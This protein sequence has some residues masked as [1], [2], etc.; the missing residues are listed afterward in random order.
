MTLKIRK[1][2]EKDFPSFLTLLYE[3]ALFDGSPKAA[4]KNS[5]EQMKKEKKYINFF[6]AEEG[7]KVVG[8]AVYSFVYYTWA[9]KSIFLED[10]YITS[11]C[12]GKGIGT[13]LLTKVFE[14]AK[15]EN[16]N[17]LRWEVEE[18][19]IVAQEFYRKLGAKTGDTWFDCD[20]GKEGIKTFLNKNTKP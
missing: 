19:N 6:V 5:V 20:F 3:E 16:C 11:E 9:G 12:R 2:N 10:L 4:V 13:K 8:I 14:V 7:G 1:G 15:K 17:R 18:K